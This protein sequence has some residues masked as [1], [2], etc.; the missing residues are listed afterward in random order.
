MLCNIESGKIIVSKDIRPASFSARSLSS[1]MR[2]QTAVD[3]TGGFQDV[4]EL[5]RIT[6]PSA[7]AQTKSDATDSIFMDEVRI[8]QPSDEANTRQIS[9]AIQSHF[10]EAAIRARFTDYAARFVRMASKYEE[11]TTG[12]T[13]IGFPSANFAPATGT[14]PS[15]LGSGAIYAD[16]MTKAREM[17]SNA[18]RIEGWRVTP[19]YAL[20][21]SVRTSKPG[22]VADFATGLPRPEQRQ[23]DTLVRLGASDRTAA[24]R[25][26]RPAGGS[27][28]DLQGALEQD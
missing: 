15:S 16:D 14:Q 24:L 2:S 19:S 7:N 25:E 18:G 4:D 8:P 12:S 10:G 22:F 13:S 17:A 5:G 3:F 6:S 23:P 27:A 9:T 20:C 26:K 11:E 1:T 28:S 21:Q